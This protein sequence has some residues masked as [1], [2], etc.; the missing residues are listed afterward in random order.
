MKNGYKVSWTNNAKA[1]LED[2]IS[3]LE[4]SFPDSVIRRLVQKLEHILTLIADKLEL[5]LSSQELPHIRRAV[6]LK[7]N[8]MY[9]TVKDDEIIILSF[10]SN[11]KDKNKLE[12]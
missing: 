2:T 7:Y 8:T 9:Y 3:Y 1:E 5:Y 6:I 12:L 10:F 4:K 11:R